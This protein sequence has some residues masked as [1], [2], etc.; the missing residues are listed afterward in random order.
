MYMLGEKIDV[1]ADSYRS[2]YGLFPYSY[3]YIP[4]CR[5][6]EKMPTF[7]YRE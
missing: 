2:P 5:T 3:N 6:T 7:H 4:M 1:V